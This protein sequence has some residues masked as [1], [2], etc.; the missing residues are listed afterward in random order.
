MNYNLGVL[1]DKEF[2]NFIK[3]YSEVLMAFW[4]YALPRNEGS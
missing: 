2:E 4:Q 3:I 1:N